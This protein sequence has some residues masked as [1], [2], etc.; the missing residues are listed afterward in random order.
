M[1]TVGVTT[2]IDAS[3]AASVEVSLIDQFIGLASFMNLPDMTVDIHKYHVV[4]L[5][6]QVAVQ[7]TGKVHH[8]GRCA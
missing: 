1:P 5:G 2:D 8:M 3:A 4:G 6:R 7:Q